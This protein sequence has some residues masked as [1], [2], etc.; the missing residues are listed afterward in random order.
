MPFKLE[1]TVNGVTASSS[2]TIICKKKEK[3][4]FLNFHLKLNI[5]ANDK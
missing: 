2:L 3:K 5:P 4:M 1:L